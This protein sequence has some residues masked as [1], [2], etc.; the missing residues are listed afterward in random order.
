VGVARLA[1][2]RIDAQQWAVRRLDRLARRLGRRPAVAAHLVTGLDGEMEAF[3][4]LR[5]LG[6]T[7]VARRW[8]TQKVRGDIDLIAW[9]DGW[10]C[11]I[12]VKTRTRRDAI[13]AE[14]AVDRDKQQMLKRMAGAYLRR[15]PEQERSTLPV[16][17][18]V[19]SVYLAEGSAAEFEVFPG[20][21]D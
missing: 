20:A 11:F 14:F 3:F 13:P 19:V 12:E 6:Y 2:L 1:I 18:D 9:H 10:L 5:R 17:F 15:F 7:V 8:K 16:R 21:F 4:H